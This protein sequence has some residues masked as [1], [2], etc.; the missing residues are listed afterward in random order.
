MIC[1]HTLFTRC[2]TDE[3]HQQ[4]T[5][6]MNTNSSHRNILN[7][8]SEHSTEIFNRVVKQ[9]KTIKLCSYIPLTLESFKVLQEDLE[10]L[11]KLW[12]TGLKEY[13]VSRI[14]RPYQ[15]SDVRALLKVLEKLASMESLDFSYSVGTHDSGE[16]YTCLSLHGCALGSLENNGI[17]L[18]HVIFSNR[19]DSWDFAGFVEEIILI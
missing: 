16:Y 19:R 8:L 4:E 7:Q 3:L 18:L 15:C 10:T 17:D 14:I 13:E 6:I 5:V 2:S 12:G 11:A 1:W 9:E